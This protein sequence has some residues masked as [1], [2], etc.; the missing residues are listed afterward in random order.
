[1]K[2]TDLHLTLSSKNETPENF[3]KKQLLFKDE[4]EKLIN[5]DEC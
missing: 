2:S 3:T 1:M 5:C 4:S